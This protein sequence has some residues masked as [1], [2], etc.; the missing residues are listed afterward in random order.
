M[1]WALSPAAAESEDS[2]RWG[3][4]G[5]GGREPAATAEPVWVT[6]G[7]GVVAEPDP[8]VPHAPAAT[9]ATAIQM[10]RPAPCRVTG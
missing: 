5:P 4:S 7:A 1:S 3:M 2:E 6:I 9:T 10:T 8:P